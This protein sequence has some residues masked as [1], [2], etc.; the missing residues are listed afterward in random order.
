MCVGTLCCGVLAQCRLAELLLLLTALVRLH[1][2]SAPLCRDRLERH[3]C[4]FQLRQNSVLLSVA[5]DRPYEDRWSGRQSVCRE[6]SIQSGACRH[7]PRRP[8]TKPS[9]QLSMV[10]LGDR[11]Y[12]RP[13]VLFQRDSSTTP[14]AER[15]AAEGPRR[16]R[17]HPGCRRTVRAR[18]GPCKP[19]S[20]THLTLPTNREV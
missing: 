12:P 19:V 5:L 13:S 10:S 16:R 1:S 8:G 6:H 17:V 9:L 4:I 7:H 11:K 14:R 18:R 15:L 20:Y 3:G 2:V